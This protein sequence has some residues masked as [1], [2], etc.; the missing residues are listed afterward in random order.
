M[1]SLPQGKPLFDGNRV[2]IVTG[3]G[4]GIGEAVAR[5]LA[6]HGARVVVSDVDAVLAENVASAIRAAGGDAI[7]NP[8]DVSKPAECERLVRETVTH[9]GALHILINNAA[10]CPRVPLD[11]MTEAV[12]DTLM[13]VNLKSVFFLSRAAGNA[14]KPN[15]WG[16]IVNLS[17]TAG[18]IGGVI[19]ATVYGATKAG[20]IAMTKS[21]ARHF[22]PWNI[23]VNAV[24][25]GTVKT[26]M[27]AN[28]AQDALDNAVAGVPLKRMS[29]PEEQARVIVFLASEWASFVDGAVID[30]NG[31]A[32]MV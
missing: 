19:N 27:M 8:C 12:F 7:S 10:I 1:T 20:V 4:R 23:L 2:A 29:E 9:F 28:M 5:I 25:P 18:R 32:V 26:R 14:M 24:A 13:A 15:H 16:R 11:D 30:A 6:E 22:A 21:L 31:G 17:S 3:A